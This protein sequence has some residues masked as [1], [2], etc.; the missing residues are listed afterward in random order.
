MGSGAAVGV[1]VAAEGYPADP[2]RDRPIGGADPSGPDDGGPLLCFHGATRRSPGGHATTGGRVVTM[3]GLGDDVASARS[4]AY[5]GV[6]GV[7]LEETVIA[8]ILR[9]AE[10]ELRHFV[11][12]GGAVE[13]PSPSLDAT[14]AR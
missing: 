6:A 5:R 12:P 11:T 3:V 7:E 1:V 9:T 4:V 10:V 14:A 8:E 13:F 2:V